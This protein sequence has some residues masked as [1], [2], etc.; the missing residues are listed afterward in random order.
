MVETQIIKISIRDFSIHFDDITALKGLNLDIYRNE[1]FTIIGPANSG[2]SSLLQSLNRLNDLTP[3]YKKTGTILI[4]DQDIDSVDVESLRTRVSIVFAL[5]FPL[6]LSIFDNIAYGPRMHG[7]KNKSKLIEI[8]EKGLR[9]AYLW[10]E[11]KDRLDI[12]AM[13]L[14]GGQQQRLCIA[15]ILAVEPEIIMFDEPT[16]GLDP[17][18]TARVEETLRILKEHYTIILVTNNVAQAAR[19]GDRTAFLLM[20]E[21]VELNETKRIFTMAQDK[22]TD[23]YLTGKFG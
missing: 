5:P 6:P 18:S 10:D 2:K 17:I 11:V 19:V 21:M 23:D 15:R 8:V 13:N 22:R 1:I 7:I 9:E 14:S 20:G 12:P 3:S 16:S 4:D